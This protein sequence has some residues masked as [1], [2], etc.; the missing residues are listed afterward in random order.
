MRKFAISDIHGCNKTFQALLEQI[1]LQKTDEL[2]LLGDYVDRGPDSKGVIDTIFRLRTEGY[3]VR[4][5]KG[6]HE[7]RME[8]ARWDPNVL[9]EWRSW[10]GKQTMESF[11]VTNLNDID[12][13]YWEF[14]KELEFYFE[15][16]EYI[17]V[18]AG[19]NFVGPPLEN[20]Y[21]FLWIRNWYQDINYNW[22]KDRIIL[23]GHTPITKTQINTNYN[24]LEKAQ[25]LDIDAG[26][27]YVLEPDMGKLC[28][29][30]MTNRKLYFEKNIDNMSGWLMQMMRGK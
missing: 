20:E 8:A 4:C 17:L 29:F 16:D 13:M 22:L 30:D 10:G 2:Y 9:R 21:S 15:V 14:L 19:L 11:G 18:H 5:L 23:H 6:N 26:C 28:A 1:D 12:Q 24:Q 7:D 25:Y 27:F 3:Q